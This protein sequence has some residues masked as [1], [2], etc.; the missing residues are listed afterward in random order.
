MKV[1]AFGVAGA[2][3]LVGGMVGYRIMQDQVL[4]YI[5][6]FGM[7]FIL[8]IAATGLTF[9]LY[10]QATEARRYHVDSMLTQA[11][12]MRTL[13]GVSQPARMTND[14]AAQLAAMLGGVPTHDAVDG[15]WQVSPAEPAG[16]IGGGDHDD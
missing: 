2:M 1:I 6:V 5:V 13:D 3:A 4:L 14:P 9:V 16:Q 7:L 12:V 11:R 15:V 8:A 10:R